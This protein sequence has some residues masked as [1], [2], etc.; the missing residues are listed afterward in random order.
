MTWL[1][2]LLNSLF[3]TLTDS[4]EDSCPPLQRFF[5]IISLIIS[6]S[7][8]FIFS[9][10]GI[11]IFWM[12]HGW[13]LTGDPSFLISHS[14]AYVFYFLEDFLDSKPKTFA[15]KNIS[16]VSLIFQS[17]YSNLHSFFTAFCSSSVGTI[18][19]VSEYINYSFFEVFL[20]FHIASASS[21]LLMY[22]LFPGFSLSG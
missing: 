10:S 18:S 12:S 15:S 5:R 17:S 14:V 20:A 4:S 8:V 3:W 11:P 16:F 22:Y 21:E 6:F 7:P 1:N 13:F 19:Y 9:H 2:L